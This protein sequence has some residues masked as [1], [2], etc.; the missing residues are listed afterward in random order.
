MGVEKI[1]VFTKYI[2]VANS[3][4]QYV[5]HFKCYAFNFFIFTVRYVA[6]DKRATDVDESTYVELVP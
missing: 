3:V 5:K 1:T 6:F 4:K 2:N